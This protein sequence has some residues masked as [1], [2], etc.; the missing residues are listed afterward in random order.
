MG[1]PYLD[2]DLPVKQS[3][4]ARG[5]RERWGSIRIWGFLCLI[6]SV[7][8]CV[9]GN[10]YLIGPI[11]DDDAEFPANGQFYDVKSVLVTGMSFR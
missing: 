5:T 6:G 4:A 10:I 2:I 3:L 11:Q 9:W 1:H 8:L 7:S